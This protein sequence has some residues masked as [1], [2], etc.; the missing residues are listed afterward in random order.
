MEITAFTNGQDT[1]FEQFPTGIPYPL[2]QSAAEPFSDFLQKMTISSPFAER[3]NDPFL[4]GLF[5]YGSE[6]FHGNIHKVFLP[7]RSL[8]LFLFS[9]ILGELG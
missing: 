5:R 8:P 4:P 7:L 2:V 9:E 6:K 3:K 1:G